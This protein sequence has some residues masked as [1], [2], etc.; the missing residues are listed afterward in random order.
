M[1]SSGAADFKMRQ[2]RLS[3]WLRLLGAALGTLGLFFVGAKFVHYADQISWHK[4]GI[5][6]SVL[7]IPACLLHVFGGVLLGMA[8]R[9]I[10]GSLSVVVSWRWAVAAFGVS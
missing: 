6:T 5:A 1:P 7:L 10:L 9:A 8:W 4:L 3:I 2:T